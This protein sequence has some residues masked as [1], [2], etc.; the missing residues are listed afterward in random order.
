MVDTVN[1]T[2]GIRVRGS[3]Y[4]LCQS[5]SGNCAARLSGL[6][7][8]SSAS[9]DQGHRIVCYAKILWR[10][11]GGEASKDILNPGG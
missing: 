8:L 9:P 7:F 1:A 4:V 3:V 5:V 2:A 11:S 6:L 10:I